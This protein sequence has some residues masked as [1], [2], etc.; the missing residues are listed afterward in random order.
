PE[1]AAGTREPAGPI[2]AARAKVDRAAWWWWTR[3]VAPL[4]LAVFVAVA[5]FLLRVKL[6]SSESAWSLAAFYMRV[7]YALHIVPQVVLNARA[8]SGALV[9][10]IV[11]LSYTSLRVFY[12]LSLYASGEYSVSHP[13]I[14]E[15][16]GHAGTAIFVTQW[17]WYRKPKQD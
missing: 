10:P 6:L 7:L 8:R 14:E 5:P 4:V 1:A 9:P 11:L 13:L 16:V 3:V 17:I 12:A 15:G 2:D